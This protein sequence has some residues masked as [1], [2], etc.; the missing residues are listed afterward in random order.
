M[1]SMRR[2]LVIGQ[3]VA[4]GAILAILEAFADHEMRTELV[5]QFDATSEAKARALA[6]LVE[7][8]ATGFVFEYS[9]A[10][11]PE[12]VREVAPEYFEVRRLDGTVLERSRSLKGSSLSVPTGASATAATWALTLPDGSP[13]RV[14]QVRFEP[15][16]EDEVA[17]TQAPSTGRAATL[18]VFVA[19]SSAGL[20]DALLSLRLRLLAGGVLLLAAGAFVTS[21]LVSRGLAPV[22]RLGETVAS[23]GPANL[24]ARIPAEHQPGELEPIRLR[25]NDLLERL[26][27]AFDRE[28]AFTADAAHELRTPITEIRA[29][30][31]L[32][33]RHPD[34]PEAVRHAIE[35]SA[36]SSVRMQR[37]VE[38]LLLLARSEGDRLDLR[39][40]AVELTALLRRLWQ[41]FESRAAERSLAV[42][43]GPDAPVVVITDPTLLGVVL[44][45]LLSNAADH[46]PR[47]GSVEIGAA[48]SGD[49]AIARVRNSVEGLRAEGLPLLFQR[50]W[51]G[52]ASRTDGSHAGIGLSVAQGVLRRLGGSIRAELPRAGVL[53][54]SVSLPAPGAPTLP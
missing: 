25:V 16:P 46:T 12:F 11:M 44:S 10:T 8:T 24:G 27:Q 13:G 51:R 45:N 33:L 52:D 54:V 36:S 3:V 1:T 47:G 5:R 48:A 9:E 29:A 39:P 40:E 49:S 32:A 26:E 37:L 23:I 41:P 2:R 17:V 43:F 28:R 20:R 18:L 19:R 53:E 38:S 14:A 15:A 22:A 35:T 31:E 42:S 6:T 34:D 30:A 7:R 50:F 21:R 4:L